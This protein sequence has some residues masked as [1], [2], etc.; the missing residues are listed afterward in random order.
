[1]NKINCDRHPTFLG[2]TLDPKLNFQ[3]HLEI[4]EKKISSKVNLFKKIKSLKI[5]HIKI[6]S[7]LFKSL[8]RPI[9]DYAFIGL[10]SQ[11]QKIMHAAQRIQNRFLRAIKHFPPSTRLVDIHAHFKIKSIQSRSAE[12]LRKFTIAKRGHDLISAELE[13]FEKLHQENKN[14]QLFL[15]K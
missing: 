11:T 4:M 6:N 15:T 2:I 9:F 7:I 8:I 1:M 5:N 14:F 3:K 10:S 12:F 13:E